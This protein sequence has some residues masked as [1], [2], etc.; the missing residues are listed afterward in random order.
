MKRLTRPSLPKLF[1]GLYTALLAIFAISST[2]QASPSALT[3]QGR[4]LNT[5]GTPLEYN[6][7]SFVFQILNPAG[8]CII[9]QEQIS[10]YNMVNSGGVF[11]IPIGTGSI[12]FPLG[13]SSVLDAFNNTTLFNCGTCT[14]SGA[15]YSCANTSSTYQA[16]A[17]DIRKL[18]VSFHDGSGWKT[19][20]PDSVVR[21]VPF[22]GYALAAEKL[23]TNIASDFLTKA[24]IPTCAAG[25]FLS[26]NGSAL[27]CSGIS[28]ANGGTVTDVT[29][30]NS[31]LTVTNGTSTPN[32]T[33]N[34]GTTANTVAAGND[35][36]ITNALQTGA[37]AGGDL[38]G[39][40]P[41]PK[42][43]AL[44]GV[45]V[46][47][48]APTSGQVLKYNGTNWSANTLTTADVSN[49]SSTLSNYVSQSAF[50]GYVASASCSTSQTMYW[51]SVSGS[52]L[53]QAINVGLAGDVTGSIGA[54][55]V[56]ALQNNPVDTTAPTTN[57]VLQWNGSKWIP[58]TLNIPAGTVTS[59]SASAPLSVTNATTTPS[60]TIAQATTSTSGYLSSSDWN[61][62]NGKQ[63]AG[64]YVTALT[65][66]VTAS[67]P[68]S[69]AA[70]V[71]KL[72]GSTLTLTAPANK[73]YLKFNGTAFVNS[74]L[75]ASDLSGTLPA[76]NLPAFTGDVT[77]SAGSATLTLAATGT[78]G[79]YYKVTTDSKGR[80]TSGASSLVAADIPSLDWAKIT[81][82]KPNSLSG[83]GINDPLV[84]N[85]G[86]T[87][88]IQTGLDAAKPGSPSAG[89]IYFATDTF[90]IYQ[91]NSGAWAVLATA[92]GT[93]GTITALTSD[94]SASGSG[95]V[96]ATV[97]AVGGSTAANIH[98]AELLAN[99]ATNANTPSTLVKRD[100]SGNFAASNITHSANTGDIFTAGSGA[101]T[102]TIQGPAGAIGTSYV[103]KLPTSQSSGTQALIND[104]SGNLS[105]QTLTSGTV[106]SVSATSPLS[107][108]GG[109]TPT[110]SLGGLS[111]LG[112]ANQILGMNSGATGYEYK[113]LNGTANQ[114]T[115]AN[116]A[117]SVT[118]STPQNIHTAATPT[119]A[120]LTLSNFSTAG[121]VK[122]TAAGVLSGGNSVALTAD[123]SGVLPVASGGTNTNS[124]ANYSVIASNSAGTALTSVP[125]TVNGSILQYSAT[126]P[127]FSTAS[128]PATT[129]ANQL[130]YSS[131]N[132]VVGGL[133][134]ANNSVLL[135]NGSGV[136]SFAAI[137]G[138]NFTQYA[139]LA[140]RAGG[141]TLYGGT[142]GSNTLTLAG[143]SNVTPGNVIINSAGG[144]VG[145]GTASPT[146]GLHI[147]G[148]NQNA[149]STPLFRITDT[150]LSGS[151]LAIDNG[152]AASG[153][154]IISTGTTPKN[155]E[156]QSATNSNQL[157]LATTGAVG[158][159]T[160]NPAGMFGNTSTNLGDG[161]TIGAIAGNGIGPG[162]MSWQATAA[163][164]VANLFNSGTSA[165]AHGVQIYTASTD[166][167]TNVLNVRAN[168]NTRLNVRGDGNVLTPGQTFFEAKLCSSVVN[169][170]AIMIWETVISNIG[171]GYNA[172]TGVFTAPVAG[173][174][175]F[176][177]NTLLNNA[178]TGEFRY[179]FFKN[180][181]LYDGIITQKPTASTWQT[182]QGTISTYM[183]VGETMSIYY[184]M[185]S[186]A[187]YTDCHYNRFWGRLGG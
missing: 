82:G 2:A 120:G 167:A 32:L 19:I 127:V 109:A 91:F 181:A 183:N 99:A 42:V 65:G 111:G 93:G 59:V 133:A 58:A 79:T 47:T 153:Y 62:F 137:S 4:I 135:T 63:A 116:A 35:S 67:G 170:P 95:S 150:N 94:V 17:G 27:S 77:S 113:S 36:R 20:S 147:N 163:G 13:L 140:G 125:G 178:A 46:S 107:S 185:G 43:A 96:A 29:S 24:G 118:L 159:N 128:Y 22:A 34:V 100:G 81:T 44:Q 25:T 108:T 126:G 164:Y 53:C 102:A 121:I 72:Q 176:G 129:T 26:W 40:Y 106:T 132:N 138:D 136:P 161:G 64:N 156:L 54:A 145:V 60:I 88:S 87:P 104:G 31:Y 114:I 166:P 177:F 6:N 110:L 38:S 1:V 103:L 73:D 175:T 92:N 119:F 15:T 30:A 172:A 143:T 98:N 148:A 182:I 57:Q 51:N 78:A 149:G 12:Q 131:A 112:T 28:G 5:S 155:L 158:V 139:L 66:D 75:A 39:S 70:T 11:D 7:V 171:N 174:Y 37:S 146:A 90:K 84:S 41:N 14:S 123:V 76:A 71:A 117:G 134:T 141:Q 50:N 187:T 48:A 165:N 23:G 83:Y 179:E 61:T 69:A 33:L 122:N 169:A 168:G 89:A 124:F 173:V 142:A 160:N 10:G 68:G 162:G 115:V 80:V 85:A 74:P 184:T 101:N 97:N 180:N 186:G 151:Y 154:R 21:S 52:F 18:R 3:Y 157:V 16:T 9:Y 86:G 8:S 152:Y 105:W 55:K 130:L 144:S 45:S 56:V 49:L